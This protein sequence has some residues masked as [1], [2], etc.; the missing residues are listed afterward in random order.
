MLTLPVDCKLRLEAVKS[1]EVMEACTEIGLYEL[2]PPHC[3]LCS[4]E[5][6]LVKTCNQDTCH[7]LGVDREATR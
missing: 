4:L 3:G 2:S 6:R 5:D 1:D 7:A